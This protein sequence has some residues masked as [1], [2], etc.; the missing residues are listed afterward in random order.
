MRI[1]IYQ[2]Y[3]R[4]PSLHIFTNFHELARK[5]QKITRGKIGW[6]QGMDRRHPASHKAT[7][8]QTDDGRQRARDNSMGGKEGWTGRFGVAGH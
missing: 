2:S 7:P 8:G 3:I 5:R 1:I 6:I 4:M